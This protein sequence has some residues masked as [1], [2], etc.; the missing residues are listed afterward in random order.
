MKQLLAV[1]ALLAVVGGGLLAASSVEAQPEETVDEAL[2]QEKVN[3][4]L[5]EVLAELRRSVQAE[6]GQRMADHTLA[7]TG[8]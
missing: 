5:L 6:R 7:E 4:R 3:A 8:R 1:A 2:V